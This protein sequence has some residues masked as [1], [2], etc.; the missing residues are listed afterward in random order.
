MRDIEN[1]NPIDPI[2]IWM[3]QLGIKTEED[4]EEALEWH[5]MNDKT[6]LDVLN[7]RLK[8][9]EKAVGIRK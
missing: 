8:E 3:K 6:K 4:Y 9:V 2:G 5:F 1:E 7:K